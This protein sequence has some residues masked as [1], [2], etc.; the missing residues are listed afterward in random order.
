MCVLLALHGKRRDRHV[1]GPF[2]E[3][4]FAA[5]ADEVVRLATVVARFG[6]VYSTHLRDE[7]ATIVEALHE[8]GDT[9]FSAGVPLIVS[10]HKCAGPAN[11]GRTQQTLPLIESLASR[12]PVAMDV[13]PYVAGSTVLREDLVDGVIDVLVSWSTPHPEMTG[14][15]L[16]SIAAEWGVTRKRYAAACSPVVPATSR[17]MRTM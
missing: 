8:A 15:T 11:W 16:A 4:A 7:M 1:V 12:Q 10:H 13:Y 5:P 3:P 6:G 17:C 9:A 2:Y 14:R